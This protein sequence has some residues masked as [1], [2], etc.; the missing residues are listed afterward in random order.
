M[1][2]SVTPPVPVAINN[3]EKTIPYFPYDESYQE[4][5]WDESGPVT[6]RTVVFDAGG[7]ALVVE[8]G[9]ATL[10][11][12]PVGSLGPSR[13]VTVTVIGNG[14][15]ASATINVSNPCFYGSV[16]IKTR[17]GAMTA[18]AIRVG[19]EILQ[20]DGS[21]SKVTQVKKSICD[22]K[23]SDE[24]HRLFADESEKLIVTYWHKIRF[25]DESEE[26]KA[27]EHPKLHEVFRE[28]PFDIYHFKL[29]SYKH[30]ILIDDSDIVAESFVTVNP[31][32]V[33]DDS[34]HH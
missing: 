10:L 2:S 1:T 28:M 11:I 22:H 32:D 17:L 26:I 14:S 21:F 29:E 31:K 6:S 18:D 15:T 4:L 25:M 7:T 9:F 27:G 24:N 34:R 3:L 23:S 33:L 16:K 20:L 19:D 30:K 12:D 8:A 13:T 5:N